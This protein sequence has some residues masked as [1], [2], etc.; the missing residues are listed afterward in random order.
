[1]FTRHT[2]LDGRALTYRCPPGEHMGHP[3]F[4][5]APFNMGDAF[6]T[7]AIGRLLDFDEVLVFD[8]QS[9]PAVFDLI[10]ETCHAVLFIAQNA[11][12]PGLFGRALGRDLLNRIRVPMVLLSMGVQSPSG[13]DPELTEADVAALRTIHERCASS[14]VRG[15]RAAAL[16]A[17]HGI[18]NT[19]VLGCPSLMWSN[20][21]QLKVRQ[22]SGLGRVGWTITHNPGAIDDGAGQGND[23]QNRWLS[24]LADR[25]ET[26]V[27]IAQ[28]GEFVLQDHILVR[29][30]LSVFDRVDH[31]LKVGPDG[32]VEEP[33]TAFGRAGQSPAPLLARFTRRDPAKTAASV[34]WVY[35]GASRP[36]Q[37]ALVENSFFSH[38]IAD[39]MANARSLDLMLG[40]RLHGNLMALA[41]GT[42]T[43]FHTHDA[44]EEELVAAIGA[45]ATDFWAEPHLEEPSE[46]DFAAFEARYTELYDGFR[47]FFERNG[48]PHRMVREDGTVGTRTAP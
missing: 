12:R 19:E 42:P 35:R 13:E 39:Y 18:H 24:M 8:F 6:V 2:L 3:H 1:M 22:P 38:R 43:V 47:N 23:H 41:Q 37:A 16:L 7:E 14:Q 9:P 25:A 34:R 31:T 27:P 21:R 26:L 10:N 46:L 44:R 17:R 32:I 30:G 36:A 45:P 11:L 33:L 40:T 29:D 4:G 20:R 5:R 15:E 28:G 48:L